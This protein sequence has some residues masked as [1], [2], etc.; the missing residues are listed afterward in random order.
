MDIVPRGSDGLMR[1]GMVIGVVLLAVWVV[2]YLV[3][4]VTSMAIHLLVLAAAV[5]IAMH[6]YA[7]IKGK[8]GSHGP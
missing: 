2:S 6:V 1:T 7:W 3:M 5:F 8:G 4:K